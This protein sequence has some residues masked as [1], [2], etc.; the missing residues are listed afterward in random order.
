MLLSYLEMEMRKGAVKKEKSATSKLA[1]PWYF[2][3]V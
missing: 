1:E 2:A 3:H